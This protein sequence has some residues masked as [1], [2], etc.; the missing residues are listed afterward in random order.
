MCKASVRYVMGMGTTGEETLG[1]A[2]RCADGG[3]MMG[4]P[5]KGEVIAEG[6]MAGVN[7]GAGEAFSDVFPLPRPIFE[8]P[9]CASM[10]VAGSICVLPLFAGF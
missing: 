9:D 2:G 10:F 1:L 7:G 6:V 4:L 5:T 3:W 8:A